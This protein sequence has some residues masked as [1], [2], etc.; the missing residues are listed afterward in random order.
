MKKVKRVVDVRLESDNSYEDDDG[1]VEVVS[2]EEEFEY[3]YEYEE[4]DYEE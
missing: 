4:Y 2:S 1:G 3:S